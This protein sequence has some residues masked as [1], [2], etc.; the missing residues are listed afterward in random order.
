M[1]AAFG[2]AVAAALLLAVASGSGHAQSE[3]RPPHLTDL[4]FGRLLLQAGRLQDAHAFLEQARPTS[5]DEAIVRLFLLGRIEMRLGLP[6]EAARRFEAILARRPAL[7]RARIE[8]ASAY[9]VAERDDKARYHF[10]AALADRLPAAVEATVRDFLDRI[11]S[12]K[13]WSSS[14]SFAL[15]PESNPARRTEQSTVVIGGAPWQLD[16][17]NRA[18]SGTGAHIS[19][20]V[21][22]SPAIGA[23]V[24]GVLAASGSAKLYRRSEWND[25]T[26]A[27]DIGL[28]W[29]S[30]RSSVSGGLRTA[31]RWL[32]DAGYS[33]STGPQMRGSMRL[34]GRTRIGAA[35]DLARV[36]H[37]DSPSRDGWRWSARPHLFHA[38]SSRNAVEAELD[39]EVANAGAKR[40]A[41]RMVGL[42]LT[43]THAF[44]GG[45]SISPGIGA[46]RRRYGGRDPIFGMTR[47]D[48][49]IRL[50]V[51]ML[52]RSLQY[53]GFA[54]YIGYS[55]E[56]N[57]SNIPIHAYRNHAIRLG[58]SRTFRA[59]RR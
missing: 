30:D 29:L 2:V 10:E 16:A 51:T 18:E 7:S 53:E 40:F 54:P 25:A 43:L 55:F 49:T 34:S 48:S 50:S 37:D 11:D 20:G 57:R 52:H 35:I 31:R 5:E 41:S 27:G 15:A 12:R 28:A 56:T 4:Q 3:D 44:E 32:G 58:I 59:A 33:R 26:L 23:G 8:L 1:P 39:L 36:R 22:F 19:G 9:F 24:R 17:D 6:R 13:R 45:L 38:P 47:A 21:S 42:G 14:L 46:W